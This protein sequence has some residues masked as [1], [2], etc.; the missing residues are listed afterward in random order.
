MTTP[1][2]TITASQA[3]AI[4]APFNGVTLKSFNSLQ[5]KQTVQQAVLHLA[6]VTDNQILGILAS[7]ITEAIATLHSYTQALG[8]SLPQ[9]VEDTGVGAVY[10]KFNPR[11][12]LCYSSPYLEQYR[13]VLIAFQSE[14]PNG[15]NE[16]YGHLPLNLF[17]S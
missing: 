16:L 10:L 17:Q 15:I 11:T 4:L 8:Y 14:H 6:R 2:T 5:E 13:G 12:G 9:S 3:Q 1:M 7:S